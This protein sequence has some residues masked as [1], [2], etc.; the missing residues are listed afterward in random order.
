MTSKVT[1][2]RGPARSA[3]SPFIGEPLP[4][5]MFSDIFGIGQIASGAMGLAGTYATNS[6]AMD[7]QRE[8]EQYNSAATLQSQAY[9]SQAVQQAQAYNTAS[10]QEQQAYNT[11][12]MLQ[13]QAYNSAEAVKG[14]DFSAGQQL[15]AENFNAAQSS[16]N[17]QFQ[18]NMSNTAYQRATADMKAAGIN[19]MVAYQQGGASSP[20]GSQ[21]G[22]GA[23]GGPN[24]S[25]GAASSGAA[26]S[27]PAHSSPLGAPGVAQTQSYAAALGSA[28]E[29]ART[30]ADVDLKSTQEDNIEAQTGQ[31]KA[32]T[33]VAEAQVDTVRAQAERERAQARD[34][35]KSVWERGERQRVAVQGQGQVSVRGPLGVGATFNPAGIASQVSDAWSGAMTT[36]KGW[37][38]MITGD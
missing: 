5:G 32:L 37:Y 11:S 29:Y 34:Y 25:S 9:N 2:R 8:A 6:A 27:G 22:I 15:E 31:S 26:S 33:K 30:K 23:L 4:M 17:R 16:L 21:A 35:D 10:V 28:F 24:A 19:P 14:R 20:A 38:N 7:R 3:S 36:A 12:Q 13:A 1:P 18:E